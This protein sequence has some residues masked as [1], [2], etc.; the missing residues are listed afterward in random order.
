[1]RFMDQ[2][3]DT[4]VG[5]RLKQRRIQCGLTLA[6]LGEQL[7]VSYQQ[8]QK[9]EKGVNR[10]SVS[11]LYRIADILDVPIHYFF[12]NIGDQPADGEYQIQEASIYLTRYFSQL[13]PKTQN[14][15]AQLA[16]AILQS[17]AD[18]DNADNADT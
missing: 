7:G 14:A 3:I 16:R 10:I 8:T 17:Q 9:Y 13:D 2:K 5:V 12:E 18:H 1:M 4:L 11:T 15:F 6:N